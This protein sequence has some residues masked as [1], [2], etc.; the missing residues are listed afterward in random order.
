M[1][2][3]NQTKSQ[4]L[5][6]CLLNIVCRQQTRLYI[7]RYVPPV[8]KRISCHKNVSFASQLFFVFWCNFH[9]GGVF[10]L[11]SEKRTK[12]NRFLT[13]WCFVFVKLLGHQV[14]FD[15]NTVYFRWHVTIYNALIMA[16]HGELK[17]TAIGLKAPFPQ[18]SVRQGCVYWVKTGT[19]R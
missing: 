6:G 14:A 3:V 17:V 7:A 12:Q 4:K 1:E 8:Y 18:G 10:R 9:I 13:T 11:S 19:A 2:L 15:W 5:L 16:K